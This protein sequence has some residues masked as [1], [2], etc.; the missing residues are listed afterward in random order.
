MKIP[1]PSNERERLQSLKLFRILDT[2]PEEIFDGFTQFASHI[3][4]TP[5]A[6]ISLV[7][8]DRQWFKSKLGLDFNETPREQAFCAHAIVQA[9]VME[10]QDTL[11]DPRFASNPLVTSDPKIRFYAGAPLLTPQ[12][13]GLGSLCVMDQKPRALSQEQKSMLAIL[14][15]QIVVCLEIRRKQFTQEDAE[16]PYRQMVEDATDIIYR[17]DAYGNFTYANKTAMNILMYSENEVI[18]HHFSEFIHPDWRARTIAFYKEQFQSKT[19]LS[20]FEYQ[21]IKKNGESIWV[22]QNVTLTIQDDWVIG[23]YAIA[24]DRTKLRAAEYALMES[25]KRYKMLSSLTSDF[26]YEVRRKEDDQLTV[27]WAT[28]SFA[29]VMGYSPEDYIRLGAWQNLFHPDDIADT[30]ARIV[31]MSAGNSVRGVARVRQPDGKYRWLSLQNQPVLDPKSGTLIGWIGAGRNITRLKEAEEALR[32]SEERYRLLSELGSDFVFKDAVMPGGQTR[33]VWSNDRFFQVFGY[34]VEEYN[35]LGDWEK[36]YHPD[37]V[38]PARERLA[39]LLRGENTTGLTRIRQSNGSYRWLKITNHPEKDPKT[40]QIVAIIGAAHDITERHLA[41][42]ALRESESKYHTMIDSML[43]GMV[44]VDLEDRIEHVNKRLCE[45][46]EY[47]EDELIG[48]I[49]NEILILPE[50][51][52]VI[53]KKHDMRTHGIAD[54]YEMKFRKKSGEIFWAL[55]GGA[56]VYD[57]GRRVIGSIGILTD[58]TQRKLAEAERER[59][60]NELQSALTEVKAL[61][62]LL[63]ICANCKNI[64]DDQGYWHQIENYISTH[65]DAEFSHGICRDCARKLYPE[66]YKDEPDSSG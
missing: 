52:E 29:S 25:E 55:V 30:E 8:E 43:E 32:Q 53:K 66:L 22:G 63:P 1:I 54:H 38:Q 27:E 5:M 33:L 40:G 48:R 39:R 19:P 14:S 50:D 23:S 2:P 3:C 16:R 41:E 15:A 11:T 46:V 42:Q 31:D 49:G 56:P 37:D 47:R 58:I 59:L 36:L 13:H 44:R 6:M 28:D 24:R 17:T 64:R 21:I 35:R 57:A 20:Y 34:S 26:A 12:G 9:D 62:G 51:K 61:S 18:G 65:S 10:V 4:G 60:I 7:D 45:M